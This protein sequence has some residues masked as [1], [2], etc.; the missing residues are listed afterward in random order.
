MHDNKSEEYYF[1]INNLK[2]KNLH[3]DTN[4]LF[5]TVGLN[6]EDRQKRTKSFLHNISRDNLQ[7]HIF[8]TKKTEEEF[9]NTLTYQL[10][11]LEDA[12]KP[13]PHVNPNVY[14]EAVN[15][16]GI[17]KCYFRWKAG[18]SNGSVELFKNHILASYE[19]IKESF[20]ISKDSMAHFDG[21]DETIKNKISTYSTALRAYDSKKQIVASEIT[22]S[23]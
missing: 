2:N 3:L 1:R 13:A 18:R 6:G 5:R 11:K 16:D 10:E 8:I 4:I 23:T 20:K 9:K 15:I 12:I 21:N 7:Q 19:T 22:L 14:T 17:Y